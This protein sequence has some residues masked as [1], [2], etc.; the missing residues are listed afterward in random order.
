MKT[1]NSFK[2]VAALILAG[3]VITVV[4]NVHAAEAA[5]P[6]TPT[7]GKSKHA[8]VH[9]GAFQSANGTSSTLT[10]HV[11]GS[12]KPADKATTPDNTADTHTETFTVAKAD[13][14]SKP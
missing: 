1:D 12:G 5:S 8:H 13:T 11:D 6:D 14:H 7:K 2:L 3:I 10:K 9:I 4:S